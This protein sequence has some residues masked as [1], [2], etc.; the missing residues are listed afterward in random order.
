MRPGRLLLAPVLCA[1]LAAPL[2]GQRP[3][4]VGAPPILQV[5]PGT[6]RVELV[7]VVSATAIPDV[8]VEV[9]SD[10]GIRCMRAPC[11]TNG[12]TWRGRA[13][14]AGR[15]RIPTT[16]L[17]ATVSLRTPGHFGDLVADSEPDGA[18]GW[19]AELFPDDSASTAPHAIKLIDARSGRA[20]ANARVRLDFRAR[21]GGRESRQAVSNS[22]GYIVVPL[23]VVARSAED[24]WVTVP[25]YRRTRLDFAWARHRTRLRPR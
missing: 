18:G 4:D 2:V 24:T 6:L 25:G 5:Q 14:S 19:I 9:F 22:L 16:V 11:P 21:A 1:L 20:I 12:R 17:Q 23:E 7:D 10:N 8:P 13:D 3:P 15:V